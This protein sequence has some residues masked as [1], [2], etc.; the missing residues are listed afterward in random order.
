MIAPST[1]Q[2]RSIPTFSFDQQILVLQDEG[3]RRRNQP[4][5]I[6]MYVHT[7][8]FRRWERQK[9]ENILPIGRRCN[10]TYQNPGFRQ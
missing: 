6:Y 5:I 3:R 2:H 10:V 8:V 1:V 9:I 7:L 4:K